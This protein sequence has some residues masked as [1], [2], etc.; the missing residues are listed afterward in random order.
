M[1]GIEGRENL[2]KGVRETT[3]RMRAGWQKDVSE[4]VRVLS[5]LGKLEVQSVILNTPSAI[6]FAKD[7]RY[8]TGQMYNAVDSKSTRKGNSYTAQAGWV[9]VKRKYFT[10]QDQGGMG[11]GDLAGIYITPMNALRSAEHLMAGEAKKMGY[12][13]T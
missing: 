13:I 7:N 9:G 4:D 2:L 12:E 3:D 5:N 11:T 6:S 10:I 1:A 8:Y